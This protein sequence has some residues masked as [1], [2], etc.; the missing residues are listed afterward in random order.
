[1]PRPGSTLIHR[2]LHTALSGVF[3]A[4][5]TIQANIPIR[6]PGGTYGEPQEGWENLAAHVDLEC[7]ISPTD[8]QEERTEN[9]IFSRTTHA[10]TLKGNYPM[11]TAGMRAQS[12]GLNFDIRA[13]QE[14]GESYTTK[15]NCEIVT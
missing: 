15:L 14:D 10:I 7:R 4:L 5:V 13:A 9:E 2:N 12:G 11:I 6:D 1:M 8:G 3:P